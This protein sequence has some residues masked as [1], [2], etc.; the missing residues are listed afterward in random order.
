MPRPK[1]CRKVCCMPSVRRFTPETRHPAEET[2]V[3]TVDEYEALRL[4]DRMGY[5]QEEC[6]AYMEVARTTVQ[7]IYNNARKKIAYAL[8]EGAT[9]EIGGGDYQLCDGKE[10]PCACGGCP[11]HRFT[12]A[13]GEDGYVLRIAIPVD[14]TRKHVSIS[15]GRAP[16]MIFYNTQDGSFEVRE[17]PAAQVANGAGVKAAEFVAGMN[18]NALI[19]PRLGENAAEVLEAAAVGIYEAQGKDALENAKALAEGKLAKLTHF[20]QGLRGAEA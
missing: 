3:L 7:Q 9:L 10:R 1:K 5:S 6:C 4:I 13:A 20:H 15:F 17:N 2:V 12:R 19:T 14:E 16:F 18:V 11:K 8:V